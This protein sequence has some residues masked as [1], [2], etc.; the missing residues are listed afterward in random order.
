MDG[1]GRVWAVALGV[2]LGAKGGPCA[3]ERW[4]G[5]VL[6]APR[7]GAVLT[8]RTPSRQATVAFYTRWARGE[9]EEEAS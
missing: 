5:Q 7:G 9:T 3:P 4:S 6:P 1:H 8:C 2:F